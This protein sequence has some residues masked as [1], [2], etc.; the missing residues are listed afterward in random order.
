MFKALGGVG[1]SAKF[2]LKYDDVQELLNHPAMKEVKQ[3]IEMVTSSDLE[4]S[5]GNGTPGWSLVKDLDISNG[6]T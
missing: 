3:M 6:L 2:D 1:V 4:Q 5:Y